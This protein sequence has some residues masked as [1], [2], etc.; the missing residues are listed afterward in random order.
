MRILLI[1]LGI[2]FLYRLFF[3]LILPLV[4]RHFMQKAA[5]SMEGAY[6]QQQ[7]TPPRRE[8]EVR[9]ETQEEKRDDGE[10]VDYTEVR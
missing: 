3:N 1:L 2:Y 8:G 10:Y 4:A 7:Q 9:I 5:Q 6:R